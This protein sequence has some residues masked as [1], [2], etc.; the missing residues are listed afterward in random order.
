VGREASSPAK[1]EAHVFNATLFA[2]VI[3]LQS[4]G[5]GLPAARAVP[6]RQIRQ[7]GGGLTATESLYGATI[8]MTLNPNADYGAGAWTGQGTSGNTKIA[9][10]YSMRGNP[11][12]SAT[13][14]SGPGTFILQ[15]AQ[16]VSFQRAAMSPIVIT[17]QAVNLQLFEVIPVGP[18][19]TIQIQ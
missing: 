7:I 16:T 10:V 17:S 1:K 5:L 8:P 19:V 13:Y 14:D 4:C 12:I 2:A 6:L 9:V 18:M 3:A 11:T 15:A